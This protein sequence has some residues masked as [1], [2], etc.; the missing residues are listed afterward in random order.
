MQYE[1]ILQNKQ[2]L[3]AASQKRLARYQEACRAL[4]TAAAKSNTTSD[5]SSTRK[6][7]A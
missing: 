1:P 3:Q 5:K 6:G 2:E 4:I 7:E